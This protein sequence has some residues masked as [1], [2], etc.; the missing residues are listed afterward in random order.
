VTA[1]PLSFGGAV[2]GR[3][4]PGIL[5]C[6]ISAALLI[7]GAVLPVT[8]QWNRRPPLLPITKA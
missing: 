7:A 5:D 1:R 2:C 8:V 3:L 4:R 6:H